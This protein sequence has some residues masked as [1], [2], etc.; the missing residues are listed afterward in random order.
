MG[1]YNIILNV[2]PLID[3]DIPRWDVETLVDLYFCSYDGG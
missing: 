2:V 3:F 1:F